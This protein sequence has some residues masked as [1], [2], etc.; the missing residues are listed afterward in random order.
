MHTLRHNP[1]GIGTMKLG[2]VLTTLIIALLIF[3]GIILI[4]NE[5]QQR[6]CIY[7]S[8]Q[9]TMILDKKPLFDSCLVVEDNEELTIIEYISKHR[10]DDLEVRS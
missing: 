5:L 7:Y 1:R 10:Y 8:D 4:N 2:T 6:N 3:G 9:Y